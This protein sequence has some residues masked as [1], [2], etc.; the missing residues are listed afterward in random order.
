MG[1]ANSCQFHNA[2]LIGDS[3]IYCALTSVPSVLTPEFLGDRPRRDSPATP[4]PLKP[5][6]EPTSGLLV[7]LG[8]ASLTLKRKLA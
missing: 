5:V 7:L 2:A 6:L 1:S 3:P 8:V 4:T